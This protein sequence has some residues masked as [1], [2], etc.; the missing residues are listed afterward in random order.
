MAQ[1]DK[2]QAIEAIGV[3]EETY[4]EL[5]KCF[6]PDAEGEV[7][8]LVPLIAADSWPEIARI[9]HG[10]K[11]M[12]GNLFITHIQETAKALEILAKEGKDRAAMAEKVTF[13]KQAIDQLK[14]MV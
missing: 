12:A 10:L 1:F 8:K 9:G 5:L 13:L 2:K 3:D 14:Q 6:L 7:E 4:N 11:G